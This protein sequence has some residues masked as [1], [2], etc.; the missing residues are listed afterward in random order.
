MLFPNLLDPL[1]PGP[2]LDDNNLNWGID[3]TDAKNGSASGELLKD[4]SGANHSLVVNTAK[5]VD[6]AHQVIEEVYIPHRLSTPGNGA[7]DFKM[8][9][10]KTRGVT[11]GT[12]TYGGDVTLH[13]PPMQEYYHV[14][15]TLRGASL[16][17]Q[18]GRRA[19]TEMSGAGAIISPEDVY[20]VSWNPDTVQHAL[21]IP[22]KQLQ[23][24]LSI[25]VGRQLE[26]IQFEL[27]FAINTALGRALLNCVT[28]IRKQ[29]TLASGVTNRLISDQLDSYLYTHL[30]LVARHNHL[31]LLEEESPQPGRSH[32][33]R[34]VELLEGS[35]EVPWT[36]E[37]LAQQLNISARALQAGFRA[38]LGT[39]PLRYLREQRLKRAHQQL[40]SPPADSSVSSIAT[41][42][43][44]THLGRFAQLYHASYGVLP[45]QTFRSNL[46]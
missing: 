34:A 40:L 9:H 12:V 17:E 22:A 21:R 3:F 31:A 15:L 37:R 2:L 46:Q 29:Q 14:N 33:M 13:C 26:P 16:V 10:V 27:S 36:I 5:S 32:I 25:L 1:M 11:V 23:N 18:R 35:P 4:I 41:R 45:S 8:V 6:S 24:H 30:L 7:I 19:T 28:H 20:S 39:T 38:E 44:F 42:W 43:G